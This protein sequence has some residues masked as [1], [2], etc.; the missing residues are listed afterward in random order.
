MFKPPEDLTFNFPPPYEDTKLSDDVVF[1]KERRLN[2]IEKSDKEYLAKIKADV[3][4]IYTLVLSLI[5]LI[6]GS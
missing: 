3:V 1:D 5:Y 2:A 4:F 6:A